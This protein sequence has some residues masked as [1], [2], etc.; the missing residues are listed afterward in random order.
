MFKKPFWEEEERE[1][2]LVKEQPPI[3]ELSKKKVKVSESKKIDD[4]KQT[5]LFNFV[6]Q[7]IKTK[8]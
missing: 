5:T 6:S 8:E 2:T 4:K 3:T 1:E 7:S